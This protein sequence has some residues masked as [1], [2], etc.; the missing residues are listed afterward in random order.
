MHDMQDL[1]NQYSRME[2]IQ[3]NEK[4]PLEVFRKKRPALQLCQEGDSGT[5]VLL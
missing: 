2:W 4:Q 5:G 1:L 3:A